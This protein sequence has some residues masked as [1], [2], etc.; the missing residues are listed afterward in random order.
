MFK[1]IVLI[2]MV[3]IISCGIVCAKTTNDIKRTQSE[4][5]VVPAEQTYK[6][7]FNGDEYTLKYS[8][9]KTSSGEYVNEY[10]KQN[11]SKD[12]WTEMITVSEFPAYAG[13][14]MDYAEMILSIDH[15][16]DNYDRPIS[17]SSKTD[18]VTFVYLMRGKNDKVRYLDYNAMQL[19]PYKN[20]KGLKCVQYTKRYTYATREEFN[21]AYNEVENTK[22][23]YF[24]L[25]KDMEMPEVIK[26]EIH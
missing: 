7:Q 9:N 24:G 16:P 1:K 4:Q 23:K 10:Y 6:L 11:E 25:I 26:K 19:L 17:C 5:K 12:N 21:S 13:S 22:N 15:S 14:T 20:R 2:L 8:T 3:A 18:K